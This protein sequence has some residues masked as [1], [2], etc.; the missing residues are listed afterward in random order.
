MRHAALP[1]RKD[2]LFSV[3]EAA[4]KDDDEVDEHPQAQSAEGDDHQD[5]CSDLPDVEPV[6]PQCSEE[7]G[8]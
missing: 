3:L 4:H 2:A 8:E 1:V 7:E 5:A 6:D